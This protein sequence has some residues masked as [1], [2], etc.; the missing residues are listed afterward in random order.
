MHVGY[1]EPW[2]ISFQSSQKAEMISQLVAIYIS[3]PI[4]VRV[5]L[6][7]LKNS[8]TIEDSVPRQQFNVLK[9]VK[10]C[11]RVLHHGAQSEY[12]WSTEERAFK[13]TKL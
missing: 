7:K 8:N 10:I 6:T 4:R 9:Y 12:T 5:F 1:K 3:N 11:E 2:K 13:T